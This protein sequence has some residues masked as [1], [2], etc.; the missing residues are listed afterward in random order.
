MSEAIA[1]LGATLLF[2]ATLPQAARLLR[3]RRADEMGW[4]F[5]VLNS[6]GIGLLA[7][8]SFEIGERAFL[9]L[10][11]GTGAFWL[12]VGAIKLLGTRRWRARRAAA[13]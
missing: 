13:T 9:A 8:R 3:A 7:W 10:N 12:M 6:V 4:A 1:Y 2:A 5:V 11:L